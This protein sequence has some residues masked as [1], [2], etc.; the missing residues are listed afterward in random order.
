METTNLRAADDDIH[1][2]NDVLPQLGVILLLVGL[3]CLWG[4]MG[5][6]SYSA[7][8]DV[9]G[10]LT[11]FAVSS[12]V[13]LPL[14]L[15]AF[16][17]LKAILGGVVVNNTQRTLSFP[18]GGI[19]ANGLGDYFKPSFLFQYFAR[20]TI[21]LD[22]ISSLQKKTIQT[23]TSKDG[24]T[25]QKYT[26]YISYAGRFG[27]AKIKFSSEGKRDELHASIRQSNNMGEPFVRA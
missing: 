19:S 22:E 20:K 26:H 14:S 6:I 7:N 15:L 23:T 11:L 17:R 16:L 4:Y 27:A 2:V 13:L 3:V 5:Y 25:Y 12:I 21:N 24:R 18:G 10:K 8:A 9:E 1:R